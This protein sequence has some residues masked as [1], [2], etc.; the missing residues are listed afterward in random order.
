MVS[1]GFT[2]KAE[3][4]GEEGDSAESTEILALSLG[5]SLLG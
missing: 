4:S 2:V 3:Q 5:P 1:S